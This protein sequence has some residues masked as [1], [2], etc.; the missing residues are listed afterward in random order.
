MSRYISK[1][2][3]KFVAKRANNCC[4]YCLMPEAFSLIGFEIDHIIAIKHGGSNDI[5][6]L[7]FAC[8]I[9]NYRK[10]TDIGTILLPDPQ[11]IRFFNPRIDQW[12]AHFELSGYSINAKSSIGEGTIKIFQLNELRRIEERELLILAGL[13][14]HR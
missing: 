3:R 4:E 11:Y 7:A 10:G 6:N 14:P 12:E 5:D 13:F 8:A 1:K 9:C 2:D